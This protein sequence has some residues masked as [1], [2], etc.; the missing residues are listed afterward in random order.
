MGSV[1]PATVERGIEL[2]SAQKA[3]DEVEMLKEQIF[4]ADAVTLNYVEGPPSG[5]PLLLL[6]GFTNRW[7]DF[8]PLIPSLAIEWHIYALDFRGH[9][10][11]GRA[12]GQ[13]R[14]EDYAADILAFL[15]RQLTEPAI[16]FG[17]SM[18][19]GIAVM[20]AGQRPEKA[21]ALILGDP[22]LGLERLAGMEATEA[23]RSWWH[24]LR[25]LSGS[26]LSTPERASAL[27]NLSTGMDEARLRA[28]A[29]TLERTDPDVMNY[30]AEGRV[31]DY[32]ANV[33]LD[34]AMRRIACPVLLLQGDPLHGGVVTDGEVNHA[35]SL[36]A[37]GLHVRLEGV[38]HDLGL[39]EWEVTSLLREVMAFLASL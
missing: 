20:C 8:L 34:E 23:Q 30:H 4:N 37:D 18:G 28:W 9:G 2:R 24:Y 14:P 19:A 10:K 26:R 25:E 6:H 12:G 21:R 35:L 13:Y 17:H 36:L 38:G 32:F 7:Q 3:M 39:H 1:L 16:L 5:P 33:A 29:K 22:P 15:E 31:H 27:A 11:S